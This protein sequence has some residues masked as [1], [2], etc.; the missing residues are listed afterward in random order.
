MTRLS[1]PLCLGVAILA[2]CGTAPTPRAPAEVGE[3]TP[4]QSEDPHVVWLEGQYDHFFRMYKDRYSTH[5]IGIGEGANRDAAQ[6]RTAAQVLAIADCLRDIEASVQ[7]AFSQYYEETD[8]G[9]GESRV[10]EDYESDVIVAARRHVKPEGEFIGEYT[11]EGGVTHV[12]AVASISRMS[13][14]DQVLMLLNEGEGD[15]WNWLY[16]YFDPRNTEPRD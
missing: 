8:L 3:Q 1:V 11:D 13:M 7:V 4:A 6:A 10:Y 5:F 14:R 16:D 12:V 9:D 2:A 15:V